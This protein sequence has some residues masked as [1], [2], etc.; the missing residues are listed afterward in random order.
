MECF[1]FT[2]VNNILYKK[3]DFKF[4]V[5]NTNTSYNLLARKAQ[6]RGSRAR[7]KIIGDAGQP[8]HVDR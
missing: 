6:T 7:I 8:W 5:T 2:N 1:G 3:V 4:I